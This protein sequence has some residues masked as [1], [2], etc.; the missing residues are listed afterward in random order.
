MQTRQIAGQDRRL[1]SPVILTSPV[2]PGT[3][4]FIQFLSGFAFASRAFSLAHLAHVFLLF[5][6]AITLQCHN[7]APP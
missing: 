2:K 5:Q 4:N 7:H 6:I 3:Q 1:R